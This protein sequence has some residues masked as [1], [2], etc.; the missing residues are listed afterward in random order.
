M[1]HIYIY[2]YIWQG[3]PKTYSCFF[4]VGDELPGVRFFLLLGLLLGSVRDD[5]R[6]GAIQ[7]KGT[8]WLRE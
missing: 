7:P 4:C 2:I 6:Y 5:G 3:D 8:D 1:T